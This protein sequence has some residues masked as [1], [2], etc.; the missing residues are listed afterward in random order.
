M[1]TMRWIHTTLLC[2]MFGLLGLAACKTTKTT[3]EKTQTESTQKTS[4][5]AVS[6]QVEK[7]NKVQRSIVSQEL[8]AGSIHLVFTETDFAIPVEFSVTENNGTIS[9]KSNAP[10]ASF[11]VA[12]NHI[13]TDTEKV[14]ARESVSNVKTTLKATTESSSTEKK[15]AKTS[16][17]KDGYIVVVLWIILIIIVLAFL[18]ALWLYLDRNKKGFLKYFGL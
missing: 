10:V 3:N 18:V 7:K 15:S 4:V 17:K 13:K 12:D 11:F 5:D 16:A 14:V 8:Q 1:K 6:E 9:V 2:C